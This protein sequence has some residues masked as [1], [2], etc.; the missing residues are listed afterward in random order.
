MIELRSVKNC[1]SGIV[2]Y[3][4]ESISTYVCACLSCALFGLFVASPIFPALLVV[5]FFFCPFIPSSL[6]YPAAQGNLLK[7]CFAQSS[8]RLLFFRLDADNQ[9]RKIRIRQNG[10]LREGHVRQLKE[11]ALLSMRHPSL[12]ES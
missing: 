12:M 8:S 4:I 6:P 2:A 7:A 11:Q 1:I 5:G 3:L 10:V 9:H